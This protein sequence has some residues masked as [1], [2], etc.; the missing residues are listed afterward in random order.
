MHSLARWFKAGERRLEAAEERLRQSYKAVFKGK[1]SKQDQ[2]TVMADL[3]AYGGLFTVALPD[4]DLAQR[5]GKRQVAYR[6]L[7][8]LD[9]DEA[10]RTAATQA[11]VVETLVSDAEGPI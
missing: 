2:E 8:F 3:F 5:E 6:I 4:E 7:R 1:P 10:E 11:A 9:L